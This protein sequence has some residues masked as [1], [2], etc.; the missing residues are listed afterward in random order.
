[1]VQSYYVVMSFL[2]RIH[3]AEGIGTNFVHTS[4]V[5]KADKG[6]SNL[7]HGKVMYSIVRIIIVASLE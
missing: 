1:M 7:A 5:K 6:A 4:R 2:I 3:A